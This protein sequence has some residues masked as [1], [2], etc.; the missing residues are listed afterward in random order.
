MNPPAGRVLRAWMQ[1]QA[2]AGWN[3]FV[4]ETLLGWYFVLKALVAVVSQG[5]DDAD[6][7]PFLWSGALGAWI[8]QGLAL[9][10]LLGA[11]GVAFLFGRH[12][13]PGPGADWGLP[14]GLV[15]LAA[16]TG[17]QGAPSS[18]ESRPWP[19]QP[20]RWAW[21]RWVS[22]L[23]HPGLA[24]SVGALTALIAGRSARW[25]SLAP[26]VGLG[27]ALV[28]MLSLHALAG[29][30]RARGG[31]A[32]MGLGMGRW[33][34]FL[35]VVAAFI[36]LPA[37]LRI[38][39]VAAFAALWH[40]QWLRPFR[41][42]ESQTRAQLVAPVTPGRILGGRT[43][44]LGVAYAVQVALLMS[45]AGVK[46]LALVSLLAWLP[47]IPTLAGYWTAAWSWSPAT[48]LAS[49]PLEWG[50]YYVSLAAGLRI[51]AVGPVGSSLLIAAA[52]GFLVAQARRRL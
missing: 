31:R 19:V 13:P 36:L 21:I 44:Q 17:F 14:L 16:V 50:T 22:G 32:W 2:Q 7:Y 43:G 48:G 12:A 49:R 34:A 51:A 20:A 45:V 47:V 52:F 3:A 37:Q 33:V 40:G 11:W 24:W 38:G 42:V 41:G 30:W 1:A 9:A 10:P 8:S 6:R 27:P 39:A 35:G 26:L 28:A 29:P 4:R 23:G 25:G 18:P 15:A 5:Q 46:I